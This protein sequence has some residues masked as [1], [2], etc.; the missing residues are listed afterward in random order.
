MSKPL[1]FTLYLIV[2]ISIILIVVTI[3]S[4]SQTTT[5]ANGATLKQVPCWF[6]LPPNKVIRCAY[7][8]PP[9]EKPNQLHRFHLP[10][11]Y[12][13]HDPKKLDPNPLIYISGGPG[14]ATGIDKLGIY[15][16]HEWIKQMNWQHDILFFDQRAIGKGF[17]NAHCPKILESSIHN[18]GHAFSDQQ[19]LNFWYQFAKRCYQHFN[20]KLEI[21]LIS[22][23]HTVNDITNLMQLYPAKS[24]NIYS[25]SYGTRVALEL[26]K[27]QPKQLRSV[28]LDSVYPQNKNELMVIPE[29]MQETLHNLYTECRLSYTCN[30]QAPNLKQKVDTI[31]KQLN[32]KP[33]WITVKP[34]NYHKKIKVFVNG[35]R[36]IWALY[37]SMYSWRA[38]NSAPMMLLQAERGNYQGLKFLIQKSAEYSLDTLFSIPA[39]YSVECA[40]RKSE[41][42]EKDYL[43]KVNQYSDVKAFT[44]FQWRYDTCKVWKTKRANKQSFNLTQSDVPTLILNGELDPVTPPQWAIEVAKQLK[45]SYTFIVKG[46]GHAVVASDDCS[47]AIARAFLIDPR[48]K[49]NLA[50]QRRWQRPQ[51]SF[52]KK[53]KTN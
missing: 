10:V 28:I 47:G 1:K 14:Y 35:H 27:Q 13:Q 42:Q 44:Q 40:D 33:I 5:L 36:F 21:D 11:V 16:W 50:C 6:T 53:T 32:Q 45:N 26:M 31:V 43:Q 37:Q 25:I 22:T 38:I 41:V 34:A 29:L 19:D 4:P 52:P 39:F 2:P 30:Q 23:Q 24:W 12:F 3:F 49:P 17:P 48:K 8:T 9:I 15:I 20:N 18:L 7:Y 46:I 51:F